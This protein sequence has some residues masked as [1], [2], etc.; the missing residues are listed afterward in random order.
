MAQFEIELS[1]EQVEQLTQEA[2]RKGTSPREHLQELVAQ[3]L[4]PKH[5]VSFEEATQHVLAK[6]AEL[7]ERLS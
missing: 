7:Y 5:A 6:N 4:E 3:L 1:P 2:E